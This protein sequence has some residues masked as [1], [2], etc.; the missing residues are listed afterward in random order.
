[1]QAGFFL[2]KRLLFIYK[3]KKMLERKFKNNVNKIC[4]NQYTA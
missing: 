2:G 1:M 4:L 3:N